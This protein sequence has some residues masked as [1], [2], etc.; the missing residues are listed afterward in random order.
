MKLSRKVSPETLLTIS[1]MED[2]GKVADI[3]AGNIDLKLE[4]QQEILEILPL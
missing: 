2:Y 1:N 3:I 4:E